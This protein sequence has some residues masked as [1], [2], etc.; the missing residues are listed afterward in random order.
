MKKLIL[1]MFICTSLFLMFSCKG[2][3]GLDG[4]DGL[5]GE[6]YL[7]YTWVGAISISD[8][9]PSIPY[10]IINNTYYKSNPGTYALSYI[11]WDY[12]KWSCT[13]TISVN[14]G[15]PGQSG[16]EGKA[17]WKKG[18]DGAD[19]Q[20]GADVYFKLGL[21]STGPVIYTY[22]S[23]MAF[24]TDYDRERNKVGNNEIKFQNKISKS[25]QLMQSGDF[26]KTQTVTSGKYKITLKYSKID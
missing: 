6:A 25:R 19:G 9:N 7:A 5:D 2:S 10:T 18:T 21:W 22:S 8:S 23:P 17:F 11:S 1:I 15:T 14:E 16:G 13:Y 20:D 3:D 24:T 26:S 4:R 12:S